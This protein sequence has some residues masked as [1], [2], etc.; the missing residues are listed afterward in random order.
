MSDFDFS[1]VIK[2]RLEKMKYYLN[3][4]GKHGLDWSWW[5]FQFTNQIL[6]LYYKRKIDNDG[7]YIMNRAWNNLI[8]LDACRYDAFKYKFEKEAAFFK[9]YKFSFEKVYSRGSNTPEFLLENFAGGRYE[10]VIYIT[11]NPYVYTLLPRNTFFKVIHL[12]RTNWDE[13]L[14]T[15][16]PETVAKK[17]VEIHYTYPD[18]RLIIHFMQPHP[19]FIG[20]YRKSGNLFCSI[21]L[22]EGLIEAIK[23]YLSNLD[24][25]FSYIKPLIEKLDGITVVTSD[26]GE[27][28][29]ELAPPFII[30]IYGHPRGIRIPSIREVPWL[31]IYKEKTS[32]AFKEMKLKRSIKAL[33]HRLKGKVLR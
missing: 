32:Q 2:K 30:P 14:G 19:P 11:A 24:L 8:I 10:D 23:A 9:N 20:K 16:H 6:P 27:A 15:V 21:A 31:T 28:W 1:S 4:I 7:I 12:W 18:K 25:V 33:K 5:Y 22:K 13:N 26:H 17:A 29:G 3:Q